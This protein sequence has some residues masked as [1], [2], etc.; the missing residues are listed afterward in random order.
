MIFILNC[1]R[2]FYD[3]N[4]PVIVFMLCVFFVLIVVFLL[5]LVLV[6]VLL[7]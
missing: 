3:H 5:L 1:K 4:Y 6:L 2:I 7:L